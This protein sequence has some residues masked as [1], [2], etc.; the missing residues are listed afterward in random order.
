MYTV[1][2]IIYS[3]S[4]NGITFT[5]KEEAIEYQNSLK[6]AHRKVFWLIYKSESFMA[7]MIYNAHINPDNSLCF[8]TEI[9]DSH[10]LTQEQADAYWLLTEEQYNE[11]R[12]TI[13]TIKELCREL[14]NKSSTLKHEIKIF[15]KGEKQ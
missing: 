11:H 3:F 9:S 14:T 4:V 1:P 13:A 6:K 15:E 5:T 12:A 10:H 8:A 7:E 2:P